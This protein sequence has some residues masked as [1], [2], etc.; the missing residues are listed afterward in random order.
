M[1]PS[2]P[3]IG[4]RCSVSLPMPKMNRF[5]AYES[6]DSPMMHLE[7]TRAQ[8]QPYA[9]ARD[10]SDSERVNDLHQRFVSSGGGKCSITAFSAPRPARATQRLMCER[11]QHQ[12][13]GADDEHI[14][15]EIEHE[16]AGKM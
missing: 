14:H 1:T 15:A 3:M 8:Q 11:H 6:N 10:D 9:G 12:H 2:S 16:H 7:C 5:V 13:G 4:G